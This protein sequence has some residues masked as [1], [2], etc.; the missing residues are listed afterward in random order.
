MSF[1]IKTI[2]VLPFLIGI[3]RVAMLIMHNFMPFKNINLILN[4]KVTKIH[5]FD[6]LF[7]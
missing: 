1:E 7:L 2:L 3:T 5:L 4:N 6:A